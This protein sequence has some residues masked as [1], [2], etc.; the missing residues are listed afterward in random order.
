M[1]IYFN[2]E[3][4][5]QHSFKNTGFILQESDS[6]QIHQEE[7][8]WW[9][10]NLKICNSRYLIHSQSQVLIQTDASRKGRGAVCQKILTGGNSQKRNS[11][12]T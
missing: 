1:C 9:I 2:T 12:Y 5:P 11:C 8:Q 7:L 10:Q 3:Y 4:W 6:K